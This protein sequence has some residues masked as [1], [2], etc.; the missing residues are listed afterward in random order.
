MTVNFDVEPEAGI[1]LLETKL[2]ELERSRN[3]VV[4]VVATLLTL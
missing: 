3:P 1:L 2:P 4:D